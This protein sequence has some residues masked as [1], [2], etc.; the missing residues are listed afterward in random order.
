MPALPVHA[1]DA[2]PISAG[3]ATGSLS[4]RVQNVVTGQYLNN[5]RV[6]VR[7][8]DR[9]AFTDQSGTYRLVQVPVGTVVLEVFFTGLDPQQ[10]TV[11]VGEGQA[12][13]QDINLSSV[14]RY[15]QNADTVKLDSFVVS[16][17]RETDGATIAI[18]EQ[19][20]APNI[21]NVMAADSLGDIIDGNAG[22]FLKFM[23]GITA[24]YDNEAG[25]TVVA[26][27]VRGFGDNMTAIMADGAQMANQSTPTG[28]SRSFQ[29]NQVSIN[30]VSRFEVTKVP[31]PASPAD[32]LAGSINMV[33]KSAFERK[34]AQLNYRLSLSANSETLSLKRS[35]HTDDRPVHKILPNVDFDYTLP[36]NK[37]FGIV[38][39]GLST[40]RYGQQHYSATTWNQS[41]TGTNA[42]INNP[43]LRTHRLVDAPR[44]NTRNSLALRADWRVAPNSVLSFVG[45][46]SFYKSS[47]I[48]YEWQVNAGNNGNPTPAGGVPMSF[49]PD[50]TIG[51][52]GRGGVTLGGS[53]SVDHVGET[54]A[55][56]LTY[57]FNN[58]TWKVDATV[59]GSSSEGGYRDTKYGH[60]RQFAI[61]MRDPVRVEFT[62][63]SPDRPGE[64]HIFDNSNREVDLYDLRNYRL[65]TARSTPRYIIDEFQGTSLDVRR[66]IHAL[67]LPVSVQGGGSYRQQ[68]RDIRREQKEWTYNGING[69][70]SPAPFAPTEYIG[71]DAHY[72]YRDM[73]RVSPARTWQAFQRNPS[74]FSQT[75]A[76]V[77]AEEQFRISNSEYIEEAV[78]ALYVQT[79]VRL[80][81]NRLQVLGGVRY[82]KTEDEGKGPLFDP[83]AVFVRNANG[84]FAR[85]AAGARIRKPEAGAVGSMEELRL[86]RRERAFEASP[87]YDGFYP[88]LHFTFNIRENLLARAA[89][90]KTYGRPNFT[91]ILPNATVNESD[92][93]GDVSDPSQ[94][95]GLITVRNT[96]L[97]PWSAHNFDLSLE[98]YTQQGGVY[99]AGVFLKE[100]SDFF[101]D[102][103]RIATAQ[104]LEELG[105]DPR[106][107]G[108]RLS[109]KF[110]S[111]DARVSGVEFSVNQSLQTLG[112]WGKFF[113]VFANGTKLRLEGDSQADFD[114]FVEESL[115]WGF[116]FSKKPF[117]FMAKWNYRG[118]QKR[119]FLPAYGPDAYEYIAPR[120]LLDLNAEYQLRQRVFLYVNA[121][122]VLNEPLVE[123]RWGS[124][125]PG[126]ARQHQTQEYG[127]SFALGVKGTF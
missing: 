13:T 103:I 6:A 113:R 35:P 16:T 89:Y 23:P 4:G 106:Y 25:G 83:N 79:E 91:D 88:S 7:G 40:H 11:E 10:V 82:E 95:P 99:S 114:R 17:S 54:F 12:A 117:T 53:S 105:L 122:N 62:G 75:S 60:F 98:Y 46:G 58:G 32:S 96:G 100:I 121:Q 24:E 27:S 116:T 111:G 56:N 68:T 80:L 37:D 29:F 86:V 92:L 15:G 38:L 84:T 102:G 43:Y 34:S 44:I 104:D 21:K 69:D 112:T 123:E 119:D 66:Q 65:N 30:N 71:R 9:V 93:D 87:S 8:T 52:T 107:V 20:F 126:Y 57:R 36:I 85:N 19:R 118:R 124:A 5:A 109:T 67:P 42:S 73:P 77:V 64:T 22:E 97:K 28:D 47:R 125:T 18:N 76:Q 2:A 115:N 90:A 74:L 45:Q 61:A 72:G 101:G 50:Y 55:G 110:N 108:W 127:I 81:N 78:S 51:A 26:V 3:A 41:A 59:N 48:G 31:T 63:I 1:A 70:L 94:V 39:T 120:S 14:A 33:S 49:G